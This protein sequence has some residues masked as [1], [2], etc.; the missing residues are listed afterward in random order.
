MIPRQELYIVNTRDD[1][2]VGQGVRGIGIRPVHDGVVGIRHTV[3]IAVMS[4]GSTAVD[5][6]HPGPHLTGSGID[7]HRGGGCGI[8]GVAGGGDGSQGSPCIAFAIG[9]NVTG[10]HRI[11][12]VVTQSQPVDLV[13]VERIGQGTVGLDQGRFGSHGDMAFNQ[14]VT[15][16]GTQTFAEVAIDAANQAGIKERGSRWQAGCR[17]R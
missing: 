12:H 11:G 5:Q 6:K 9:D 2:R 4:P 8:E 15:A 17:N 10:Q 13:Q 1:R 7:D 16:T 3:A 14:G